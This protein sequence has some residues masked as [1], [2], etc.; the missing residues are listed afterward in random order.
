MD[1]A[2]FLLCFALL[3]VAYTT[4]TKGDGANVCANSLK[5]LDAA[6]DLMVPDVQPV[7]EGGLLA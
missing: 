7:G 6:L 2:V 4:I 1:D 3:C 5:L